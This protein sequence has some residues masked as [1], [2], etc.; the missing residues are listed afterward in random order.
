[1]FLMLW[2]HWQGLLNYFLKVL[3]SGVIT[4]NEVLS[5]DLCLDEIRTRYS[6]LNY[7]HKSQPMNIY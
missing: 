7:Y 2:S 6:F 1:M 3:N 5:T 4:E